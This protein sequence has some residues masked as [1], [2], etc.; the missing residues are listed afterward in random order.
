MYWREITGSLVNTANSLLFITVFGAL[1]L[2]FFAAWTPFRQQVETG[3]RDVFLVQIMDRFLT[4][5]NYVSG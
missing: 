4:S 2:L 3:K 5:R 1:Y